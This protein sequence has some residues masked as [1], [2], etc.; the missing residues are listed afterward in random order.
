MTTYDYLCRC[1][2]FVSVF[3][4]LSFLLFVCSFEGLRIFTGN[5][6]YFFD[7]QINYKT[8]SNYKRFL[9]SDIIMLFP[10]AELTLLVFETFSIWVLFVIKYN[11]NKL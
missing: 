4:Y 7:K 5:C 9:V 3:F 2:V 11:G 6:L 8:F 1:F 10:I